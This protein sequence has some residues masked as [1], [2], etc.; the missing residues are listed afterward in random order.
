[1]DIYTFNPWWKDGKI[2]LQL[3]PNTSFLMRFLVFL[4]VFYKLNK[5][6]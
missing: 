6:F 1:M 2:P 3:V 5:I 4:D